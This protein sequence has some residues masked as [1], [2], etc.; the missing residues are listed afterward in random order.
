LELRSIQNERRV[1]KKDLR[2]LAGLFWERGQPG[3]P[4]FTE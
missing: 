1:I 2:F 4:P 3:W